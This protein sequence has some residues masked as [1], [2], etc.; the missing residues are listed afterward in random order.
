MNRPATTNP[1]QILLVLFFLTTVIGVSF[2]HHADLR[3][4]SNCV[5]CKVV[6]DLSANEAPQIFRVEPIHFFQVITF[7]KDITIYHLCVSVPKQ[8]RAPPANPPL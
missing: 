7:F 3:D 1:I 6:N 2:H 8:D 5:T 4:Y